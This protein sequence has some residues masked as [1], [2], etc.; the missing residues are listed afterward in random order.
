MMKKQAPNLQITPK[1]TVSPN[2]TAIRIS[3]GK[4]S[5]PELACKIRLANRKIQG[6]PNDNPDAHPSNG[7]KS[8]N[9]GPKK[10]DN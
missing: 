6:V 5:R 1:I 7:K 4:A 10:E 3:R 8:K 9:C 2:K